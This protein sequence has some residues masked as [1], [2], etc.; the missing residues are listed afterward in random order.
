MNG[1]ISE[2]DARWLLFKKPYSI[3]RRPT[4]EFISD[5]LAKR[6][7]R[8]ESGR[9]L[10]DMSW[11]EIHEEFVPIMGGATNFSVDLDT[12]APTGVTVSIDAGAA[13]AT[14]QSVTL[15]IATS[16]TPTT[17][18]TMKVWGD[19]DTGADANVQATEGASAWITYAT[20]KAVTLS[21][22]DGTKT[23]NLKVRDDVWNE[24]SGASDTITLDTSL[25]TPNITT[26]PDATK[27]SKISGKRV[28]NFGWQS[29][30]IFDEYKIKAVPSSGSIHTAGTTIA[31]TN[32][33]TNMTGAAGSYPAT[34]TISSSIDGRDLDV[35]DSGDGTK[36]IKIFVKDP[37][38]NW[39]V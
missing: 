35:A 7:A 25:P 30:V 21:T 23:I 32:G 16:D 36:V 18:Y 24:S 27:I 28:V 9:K 12:T 37:S 6:Q 38:G 17:G 8:I 29:D 5:R 14:S 13:Y 22:G 31:T 2:K 33:S 1:M 20:S 4:P 34:T 10:S 3:R 11:G 15:T 26:A 19:V 39:S